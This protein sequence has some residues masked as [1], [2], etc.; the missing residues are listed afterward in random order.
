MVQSFGPINHID[1][2]PSIEI[3]EENGLKKLNAIKTDKSP[4]PDQLPS[5]VLFEVRNENVAP[6]TLLFKLSIETATHD[7]KIGEIRVIYKNGSNANVSNYW[8]VSLTSVVCKIAELLIRDHIMIHF[9]SNNLFSS[10]EFGFIKGRSTVLQL[11]HVLDTWVKN[12]NEGGQIDVI[13]TD[14]AKA[15]DKVP[16]C[17]LISK[18]CSYGINDRLYGLKISYCIGVRE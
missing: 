4:G 14:F 18:L 5:R 2:M 10:K 6:L 15:F 9:I 3:T 16:H 8:P 1:N 13:Y 17:R 7:W 11:L 12:F